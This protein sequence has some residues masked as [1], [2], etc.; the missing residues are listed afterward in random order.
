MKKT[1]L[2]N[3][4]AAA[5]AYMGDAIYESR[6]RRRIIDSGARR[7]D[8]MQRLAA[9]SYVSARIQAHIMLEILD[10]LTEEERVRVKRWRNY[11]PRSKPRN[12]DT[13]TY[14]WATAFEALVG[15]LYLAGDEDRLQWLL[16]E[17]FGI[18][19]GEGPG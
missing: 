13:G 5:L 10:R 11:K 1:E 6:V 18:I 19:D 2:D 7:V 16:D 12:T 17:S 8:R 15:Y 14:Q 4:N 3:M 9:G